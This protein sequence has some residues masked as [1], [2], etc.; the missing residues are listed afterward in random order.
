MAKKRAQTEKYDKGYADTFKQ[1]LSRLENGGIAYES[2]S[3]DVHTHKNIP[4]EP[5]IRWSWVTGGVSGGSC[6]DTGDSDPHSSFRGDPE[7]DND[8]FDKILELVD[9]TISFLQYRQIQRACV[10]HGTYSQNEYYGNHTDYA[11]KNLNLRKLYEA[12]KCRNLV[13]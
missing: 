7:P 4:V 11:F 6:W 10:E 2:K 3:Y 12:L 8:S 13:P 1:F 9:P 5:H